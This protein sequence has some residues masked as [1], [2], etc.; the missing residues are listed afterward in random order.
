MRLHAVA[1]D[2][3]PGHGAVI[4]VA[5]DVAVQ[6]GA[7]ADVSGAEADTTSAR[8]GDG[9]IKL[10]LNVVAT[11]TRLYN[12]HVVQVQMKGV[13]SSAT[14]GPFMDPVVGKVADPVVFIP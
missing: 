3:N 14:N 2:V 5:Q 1:D 12:L 6:H 4:F 9:V 7:F 13:R 11:A 8:R 10:T